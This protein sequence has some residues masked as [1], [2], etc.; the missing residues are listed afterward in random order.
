MIS[1][2]D[3]VWTKIVTQVKF[4]RSILSDVCIIFQSNEF[5]GCYKWCAMAC[6]N[7]TDLYIIQ[8]RYVYDL[9]EFGI[10]CIAYINCSPFVSFQKKIKLWWNILAIII[11]I[12]KKSA[13]E[14][15]RASCDAYFVAVLVSF[16]EPSQPAQLLLSLPADLRWYCPSHTSICEICIRNIIYVYWWLSVDTCFS[17]A[18]YADES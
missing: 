18:I 9:L 17:S 15:L 3:Y 8:W 12:K 4:Q 2:V 11:S 14:I 13:D 5:Y 16:R 6:V 7:Q 10:G 1:P